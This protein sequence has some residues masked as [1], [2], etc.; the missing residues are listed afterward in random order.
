MITTVNE[1]LCKELNELIINLIG[2][3]K[4]QL[5]NQMLDKV[6]VKTNEILQST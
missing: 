2:R 3:Y 1:L 6:T 4:S 5:V